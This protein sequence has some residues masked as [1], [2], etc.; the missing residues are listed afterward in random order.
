[1][2]DIAEQV[3]SKIAEKLKE[4]NKSVRAVFGK[5]CTFLNEDDGESL[6]EIISS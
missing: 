6:G 1:M 5:V 4:L 3:F 2:L